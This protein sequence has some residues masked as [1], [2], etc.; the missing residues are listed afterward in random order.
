MCKR[1]LS[2]FVEDVDAQDVFGEDIHD[3]L[4]PTI[5]E[6]DYVPHP[7][8]DRFLNSF[9][10]SNADSGRVRRWLE[11][12]FRATDSFQNDLLIPQFLE[13]LD[14]N[15]EN[16]RIVSDLAVGQ[17]LE[18]RNLGFSGGTRGR[19][20]YPYEVMVWLTSSILEARRRA[21]PG[22]NLV[23]DLPERRESPH[24]EEYQ[25]TP[26]ALR[27]N[28]MLDRYTAICD[29]LLKEQEEEERR[30]R[31]E[32]LR[33]QW[34]QER[35]Q[36]R[37]QRMQRLQQRIQQQQRHGDGQGGDDGGD[38][39]EEN[40][41]GGDEDGNEDGEGNHGEGMGRKDEEGDEQD[42]ERHGEQD[43]ERQ[44]EQDQ[45]RHGEEGGKKGE[46]DGGA[47]D[48]NETHDTTSGLIS[49]AN[50]GEDQPLMGED[51]RFGLT[52]YS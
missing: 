8:F 47:Q 20:W 41:E 44:D 42:Q 46:E 17:Y 11:E 33:I 36:W 24:P 6:Y 9:P 26:P 31:R 27:G 25:P 10:P 13:T 49:G 5:A 39:E 35:I 32:I 48:T 2:K 30:Q 45:E 18:I 29:R 1:P 15:G 4:V 50:P 52:T 22:W 14:F 34:Q 51:D 37:Q 12:W 38:D 7:A 16:L 19:Q 28:W 21:I 40:E 43:Q 23:R 3:L